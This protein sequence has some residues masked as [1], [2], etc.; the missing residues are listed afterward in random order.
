MK[1]TVQI[2]FA[3][4]LLILSI[5]STIKKIPILN[6]II[7][8]IIVPSFILTVISFVNEIIENC[9]QC[10][11]AVAESCNDYSKEQIEKIKRTLVSKGQKT[12][13]EWKD[14]RAML[15]HCEAIGKDSVGY[16]EA[17]DFCTKCKRILQYCNLFA[18]IFL[19]LS[20]ILSSFFVK[21]FAG[22]SLDSLTMWSLTILY[23]SNELKSE[24]CTKIFSIT[25]RHYLKKQEKAEQ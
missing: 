22:I 24:L 19:F 4:T 12:D 20:L 18:Y 21:L 11:G 17:R 10:L 6:D 1:K 7:L 23:F 2:A 16:Y 15:N 5:I 3:L 13:E 25:A 8:A 9:E 14:I